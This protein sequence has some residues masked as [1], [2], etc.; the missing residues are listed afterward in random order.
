M[1]FLSSKLFFLSPSRRTASILIVAAIAGLAALAL[2]SAA[3]A[4]AERATFF[5]DPNQGAFPEYRTEGPSSSSAGRTRRSQ[6]SA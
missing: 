4:H 5:P 1:A 2:P 3:G 6:R